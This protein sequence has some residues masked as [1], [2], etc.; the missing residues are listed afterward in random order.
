[1]EPIPATTER[2]PTWHIA[3]TETQRTID[4][5]SY[6]IFRFPNNWTSLDCWGKP[7]RK[8]R[9]WSWSQAVRPSPSLSFVVSNRSH[10]SSGKDYCLLGLLY[11]NFTQQSATSGRHIGP[12]GQQFRDGGEEL[13]LDVLFLHL[14][15]FR[16]QSACLLSTSPWRFS[17]PIWVTIDPEEIRNSL[18]IYPGSVSGR[19]GNH[20]R[21]NKSLGKSHVP[22]VEEYIYFLSAYFL[23]IL[24]NNIN[25]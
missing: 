21:R 3:N 6:G 11:L 18:D 9:C 1:M 10:T 20:C 25:S 8:V 17:N 12:H 7:H 16:T 24:F 23:I 14:K 15:R 13:H 22:S 4:I 5:H 2:S 19:A